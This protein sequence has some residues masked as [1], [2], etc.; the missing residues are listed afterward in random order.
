MKM[1]RLLHFI[2]IAGVVVVVVS[3]LSTASIYRISSYAHKHRHTR[4]HSL[5]C[6]NQLNRLTR[7][8]QAV[9]PHV[10]TS[11][12]TIYIPYK[13]PRGRTITSLIHRLGKTQNITQ[14]MHTHCILTLRVK[15]NYVCEGS[16]QAYSRA[17]ILSACVCLCMATNRRTLCR[18][19]MY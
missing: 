4:A 3:P 5:A 16:G 2:F 1:R 19:T 15:T 11:I 7:L 17:H 9:Q 10:L 13:R 8:K 12:S 14:T 18:G 6:K